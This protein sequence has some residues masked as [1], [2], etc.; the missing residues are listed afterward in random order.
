MA[1]WVL[2]QQRRISSYVDTISVDEEWTETEFVLG[3]GD[4][5]SHR[6]AGR[7][8]QTL[9]SSLSL[10]RM[11]TRHEGDVVCRS[12]ILREGWSA[13]SVQIL[14]LLCSIAVVPQ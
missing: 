8:D 3:R 11:H 4:Q 7:H 2:V 12:S 1:N 10:L 5:R 13:L 9:E 6:I 14:R